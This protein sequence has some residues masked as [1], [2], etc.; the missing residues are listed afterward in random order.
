[1]Q[2]YQNKYNKKLIKK[3]KLFLKIKNQKI[4]S[5]FSSFNTQ[6]E[7]ND[8]ISAKFLQNSVIFMSKPYSKRL[9]GAEFLKKCFIFYLM[10]IT[11]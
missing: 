11:R 5:F 4:K 6:P 7:K 10:I 9:R 1:M 2:F 3:I 8:R